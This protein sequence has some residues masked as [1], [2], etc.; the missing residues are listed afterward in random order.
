MRDR[1]RSGG[2][3][4]QVLIRMKRAEAFLLV[5]AG[6]QVAPEYGINVAQ[7]RWVEAQG[8]FDVLIADP[9]ST[10]TIARALAVGSTKI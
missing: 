7:G 8:G 5:K 3:V 9:F 1:S 6:Q 4:D 10:C 2:R